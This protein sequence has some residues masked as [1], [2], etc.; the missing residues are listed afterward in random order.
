MPSL[1]PNVPGNLRLL[2]S[3]LL[4]RAQLNASLIQGRRARK[5]LKALRERKPDTHAFVWA[6]LVMM[7]ADLI[8]IA[9]RYAPGVTETSVGKSL[10]I[11]LASIQNENHEENR[12][13]IEKCSVRHLQQS[14]W[15]DVFEK[16]HDYDLNR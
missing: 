2:L 14:A 1:N 5:Q 11:A 12:R 16:P 13:T 10:G 6:D 8:G 7:S 9:E 15:L 3:V 4:H